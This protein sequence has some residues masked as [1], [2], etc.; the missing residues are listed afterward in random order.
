[1]SECVHDIEFRSYEMKTYT[2]IL[3]SDCEMEKPTQY[4]TLKLIKR[5]WDE[6]LQEERDKLMQKENIIE[7]LKRCSTHGK[8]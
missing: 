4:Q 2:H 5:S 7:A 1:M 8:I 6:L 3:K